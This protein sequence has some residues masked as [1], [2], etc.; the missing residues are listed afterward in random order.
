MHKCVNN[1]YISLF[2]S[3]VDCH[4]CNGVDADEYYVTLRVVIVAVVSFVVQFTHVLHRL[5]V[6][7]H[8]MS[9]V[10]SIL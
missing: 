10:M 1:V 9:S 4:T 8:S 5:H 2:A 7:N 6:V 3:R